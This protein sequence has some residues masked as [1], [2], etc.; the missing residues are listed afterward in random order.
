MSLMRRVRCFGCPSLP[1]ET[2]KVLDWVALRDRYAR[3]I[4]YDR[5]A[6][7]EWVAVEQRFRAPALQ[8]ENG[9]T[10]W[11]F[12]ELARI[13][14]ARGGSPRAHVD[15]L[16]LMAML[17]NHWDNK[18]DNQRLVCLGAWHDRTG[19]ADSFALIHDAGSTFGPKKMNYAA[20]R[21][22]PIWADASRCVVSMKRLPYEGATFA[23]VAIGEEGRRWIAA[24]LT[25]LTDAQLTSLFSAARVPEHDGVSDRAADIA[26]WVAAFKEKVRQI[27]DRPACP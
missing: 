10:G 25:T 13:D 4:D 21:R 23:D 12:N 15:G 16:R 9:V 8:V 6:D 5:Y 20:W 7:F 2:F 14:P 19:C 1:F 26:L 24:K 18:A 22:T 11:A 17:L 27:A 3:R